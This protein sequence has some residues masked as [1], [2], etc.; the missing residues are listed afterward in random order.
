MA[1]RN[2]KHKAKNSYILNGGEKCDV[3]QK[4]VMYYTKRKRNNSKKI[5]KTETEL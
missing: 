4:R 3:K 1:S 5:L 2:K